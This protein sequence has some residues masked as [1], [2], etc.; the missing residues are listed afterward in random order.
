MKQKP[1]VMNVDAVYVETT[2]LQWHCI[3]ILYKKFIRLQHEV[4]I[5]FA[6]FGKQK[7]ALLDW[8]FSFWKYYGRKLKVLKTKNKSTLTLLICPV[9]I[10][11]VHLGKVTPKVSEIFCFTVSNY[12]NFYYGF[13]GSLW[14]F[15]NCLALPNCP[16]QNVWWS[17]VEVSQRVVKTFCFQGKFHEG[18]PFGFS[19]SYWYRKTMRTEG[20]TNFHQK[21]FVSRHW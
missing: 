3:Y 17:T 19:N 2:Y 5:V 9:R 6:N 7:T 10:F 13:L 14:Y 12:R 20:V 21:F 8:I 15:W 11:L 18:G 4:C 16:V 1:I